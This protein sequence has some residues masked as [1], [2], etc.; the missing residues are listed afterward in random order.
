MAPPLIT[1]F[2]LARNNRA[3]LARKN[4][5]PSGNRCQC[6]S[7]EEDMDFFD[8]NS[9]DEDSEASVT[10]EL[11]ILLLA[12]KATEKLFRWNE[13]RLNW[14][15]YVS[16][17]HHRNEFQTTFRMEESPFNTLCNLLRPS[18]ITVNEIRA[19]A[20]GAEPVYPVLVMAI[21][22]RWIAGGQWADI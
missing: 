20:S 1:I 12:L 15:E 6:N 5:V 3:L 22:L 14:D 8:D 18:H 4:G 9:S 16:K 2:L 17:L 19:R 11:L 10:V 13:E 21:G 7:D